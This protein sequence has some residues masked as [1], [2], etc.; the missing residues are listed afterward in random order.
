[1]AE[2]QGFLF[3][4]R[5]SLYNLLPDYSLPGISNPVLTTIVAGVIGV[6][7]VFVVSY[8]FATHQQTESSTWKITG[9]LLAVNGTL[10]RGLELNPRMLEAGG[11]F[12]SEAYHSAGISIVVHP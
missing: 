10:M 3:S 7:I 1:M 5:D 11:V 2:Q 9:M 8:L 12:I 4:A 6:I